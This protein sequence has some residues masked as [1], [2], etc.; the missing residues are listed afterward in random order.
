MQSGSDWGTHRLRSSRH[1]LHLLGS[2]HHLL[3]TLL[4][5]SQDHLLLRL[6]K[7]LLGLL[8]NL[9]RLLLHDLLLLDR[10]AGQSLKDGD[11]GRAG[12][13]RGLL[14]RL[15]LLNRLQHLLALL[16][17]HLLHGDLLGGHLLG[18]H[19]LHLLNG[20]DRLDLLHRLGNTSLSGNSLHGL[21]WL[22]HPLSRLSR[23]PLHWDSRSW[24]SCC[25]S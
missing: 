8:D 18:R 3:H 4:R 15:N 7:Q 1:L 14:D 2:L 22:G 23:D 11:R 10:L 9:L 12:N 24:G 16:H 19:L 25:S 5:L 17:W 6:L 13:G 21:G 20:L